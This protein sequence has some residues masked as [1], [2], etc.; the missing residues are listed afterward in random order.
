MDSSPV[1]EGVKSTT[2]PLQ[3]SE[4]YIYVYNPVLLYPFQVS[5]VLMRACMCVCLRMHSVLY[6]KMFT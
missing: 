6:N 2:K 3:E 4:W 1:D 5:A